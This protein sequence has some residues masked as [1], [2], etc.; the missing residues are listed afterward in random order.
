MTASYKD[1]Y[2]ILGVDKTASPDAIKKGF[3]KIA[4]KFH[5]DVAGS[6]NQAASDAKFKEANEAYEVLSDPEKRQRYDEL[7]ANWQAG[8]SP[9][10]ARGAGRPGPAGGAGGVDYNFSGTG[11]SDFFEEY[12]ARGEAPGYGGQARG[13]REYSTR[14]SDVEAE[15]SVSFEEVLHG[16]DRAVSLR[17]ADPRS[18]E[19]TTH[20][21]Q[22]K[23]PKG[24]RERQRIR[25]AGQGEA[26]SGSG[27][28]GD[29][30]LR[31]RYTSHPFLQNEEETLYYD[32][33]ITPWEAVLGASI[34]IRSL[35]GSVRVTVPAGSQNQ[36]SLKLR[37]LGLPLSA[38][39]RG[40]LYVKLCIEVPKTVDDSE[41]SAWEALAKSS[42]FNP[43]GF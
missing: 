28:A 30:F 19:A 7:G 16:S 23:I 20:K 42:Q 24:I 34:K 25:L 31:V 12:F 39:K 17:K 26:G 6:F 5:P 15:I 27:A 10:G 13:A 29:L 41:R 8:G 18:G 9:A 22:V 4:R 2:S 33:E 32:L 3:R 37:G 21:Y 35:D 14:G 43:R 1:Y 11:F 40:D 36:Q 38:D